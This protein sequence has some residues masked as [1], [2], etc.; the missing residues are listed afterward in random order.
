MATPSKKAVAKVPAKK[1]A[2]P[3]PAKVAAPKPAKEVKS[4]VTLIE[5]GVVAT[6]PTMPYGNIMPSI[7][8]IAPSIEEARA[9]VMPVIEELYA[10]YA[11]KPRDGSRPAFLGK[12]TETVRTVVPAIAGA[13]IKKDDLVKEAPAAPNAA[14]A[15]STP[16]P[17]AQ[18]VPAPVA[19]A[20]AAVE[21]QAAP[22]KSEWALK[23]EK[24]IGLAMTEEAAEKIKAQIEKSVKILPEEKPALLDLVQDKILKFSAENVF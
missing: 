21:A 8:V 5:F 6:I 14:Q 16:A 20:S 22:A 11:E 10:A 3:K 15:T 18:D 4:K 17:V 19:T 2:A 13:E 24:M 7:K 1:A 9:V 23:A 12:V